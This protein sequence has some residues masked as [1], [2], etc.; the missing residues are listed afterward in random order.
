LILLSGHQLNVRKSVSC[1]KT[2]SALLSC[3]SPGVRP[4][5]KHMSGI[6]PLITSEI[7]TVGFSLISHIIYKRVDDM[8]FS[9]YIL[10]TC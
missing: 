4:I 1:C 3:N 5:P 8:C 2:S 6:F 10:L 7:C 9:R